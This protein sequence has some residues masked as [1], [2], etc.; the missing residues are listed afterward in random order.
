[1]RTSQKQDKRYAVAPE[2]ASRYRTS[3]AQIYDWR[4]RGLIP[5][6]CVVRIGKKILFDLDALADW[7][8]QGGS[9]YEG[10]EDAGT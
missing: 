3:T 2:V 9:P 8:T 10:N 4:R 7:A 6:N 5:T 1:M